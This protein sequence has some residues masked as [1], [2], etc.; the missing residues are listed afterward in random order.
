[1]QL[2]GAILGETTDATDDWSTFYVRRPVPEEPED[3]D[4]QINEDITSDEDDDDEGKTNAEGYEELMRLSAEM[5]KTAQNTAAENAQ[6]QAV[7]E[8]RQTHSHLT[9]EEFQD[10][11]KRFYKTEEKKAHNKVAAVSAKKRP[12]QKSPALTILK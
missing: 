6:I 3:V 11:K 7:A 2:E 5:Q 1:M 8:F 9:E 12:K 10:V 4:F